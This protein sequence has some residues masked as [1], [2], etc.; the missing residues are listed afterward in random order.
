MRPSPQ[1]VAR[2]CGTT[3]ADRRESPAPH[4]AGDT[5]M[6]NTP[7]GRNAGQPGGPIP[8]AEDV[9]FDPPTSNDVRVAAEWA[10]GV[11]GQTI[12]FTWDGQM[13]V[14]QQ[15][16]PLGPV[17]TSVDAA[18]RPTLNTVSFSIAGV[19]DSLQIPGTTADALIWSESAVEKFLYPYF[20]SMAGWNAPSFLGQV[21]QAWYG[22]SAAA[23]QVVALAHT[24]GPSMPL[25]GTVLDPASTLSV[26]FAEVGPT[27]LGALQMLP[28]EVF[29]GLPVFGTDLGEAQLVPGNAG[30]L[31]SVPL[32]PGTGALS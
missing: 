21:A 5:D 7:A 18:E 6:T 28:L 25:P 17:E 22:Y 15:S 12:Y 1:F 24:C 4:C 31:G 29:L 14:S 16:A 26:V 23:V 2:S 19:E 30:T 13:G 11:R 20:A 32:T 27:G 10:S 3:A 8:A 9:E